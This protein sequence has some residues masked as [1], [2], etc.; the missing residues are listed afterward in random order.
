MIGAAGVVSVVPALNDL[1]YGFGMLQIA[2]FVWLGVVL[3]RTPAGQSSTAPESVRA[4]SR[5]T[6]GHAAPP[7]GVA[8]LVR[9]Q[10]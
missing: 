1:A 3:L 4:G 10:S 6:T 5:R 9:E 2:W 8:P 7:A